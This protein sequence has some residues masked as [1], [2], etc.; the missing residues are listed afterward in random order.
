[1]GLLQVDE[2]KCLRDG[3]CAAACPRRII[4]LEGEGGVP[5]V[6]PE[7]EA[8]CMA[9]GHCVAVCPYGA[10]SVTGLP[11]E[12][13]PEV[14]DSLRLSEE[15]VVHLLRSRRSIRVYWER[16][17]ERETMQHLI[18]IARYAP[19]ASNSQTVHW[20]VL[21]GREQLRRLSEITIGWMRNFLE[22][23]PESPAA[24]RFRPYVTAWDDGYDGILR[25]AP[26]L[27]IASAPKES[28]NGLVDCTIALTYLELAALPLGLGTCWAGL[29][30]AALLHQPGA[31]QA[32]GLPKGHTAHYPMMLG[33][34]KFTY[35][36]LPERKE[37]SINWR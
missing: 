9:C 32:A 37:P 6:A 28:S 34:P 3:I 20:T 36:R 24:T 22:T 35:R 1:M 23:Q 19:T 33:Y 10:V 5:T 7:N 31:H 8:D 12:A 4:E 2:D 13:C 30:Q 11:V 17:V 27:V 25:N 15:Q 16:E 29:L 14:D 21:T 26:N 18:E